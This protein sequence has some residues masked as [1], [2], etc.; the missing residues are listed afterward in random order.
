MT[1]VLQCGFVHLFVTHTV[2]QFPS[3]GLAGEPRVSGESG[4]QV[5]G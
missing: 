2:V 4:F 1:I 3:V 5:K